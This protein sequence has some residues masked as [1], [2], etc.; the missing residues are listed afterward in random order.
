MFS[1]DE[2]ALRIIRAAALIGEGLDKDSGIMEAMDR[3]WE[4]EE[5]AKEFLHDEK[6]SLK[7]E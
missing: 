6:I 7:D 3:A 4:V 2:R 1:N 5:M